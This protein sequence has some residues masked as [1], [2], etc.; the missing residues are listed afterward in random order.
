LY[1]GG[2]KDY[3]FAERNSSGYYYNITLKEEF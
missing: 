3:A 1:G 2:K